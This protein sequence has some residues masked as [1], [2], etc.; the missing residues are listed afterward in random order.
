MPPIGGQ[1]PSYRQGEPSKGFRQKH[2]MI[3]LPFLKNH[4]A[5]GHV[6]VGPEVRE[7]LEAGER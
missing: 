5:G 7:N 6:E 3:K 1:A 4:S 2:G